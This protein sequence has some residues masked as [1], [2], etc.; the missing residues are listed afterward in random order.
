[1]FGPK[2]VA[3]KEKHFSFHKTFASD[4]FV[5]GIMF[6][7][8]FKQNSRYKIN[9][10]FVFYLNTKG[11]QLFWMQDY[12]FDVGKQLFQSACLFF[13]WDISVQLFF[14]Y[15]YKRIK[16]MYGSKFQIARFEQKC[17]NQSVFKFLFAR[18]RNWRRNQCD[19]KKIAKCQ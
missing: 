9:F 11:L 4:A 18:L 16:I 3:A 13:K 12:S 2:M 6:I 7:I 19:Q 5:L 15:F 1:M 14:P 8:I 10:L 17:C